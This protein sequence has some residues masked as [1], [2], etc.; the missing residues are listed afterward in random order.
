[1]AETCEAAPHVANIVLS[2]NSISN[3]EASLAGP[4]GSSMIMIKQDIQQHKGSLAD[5]QDIILTWIKESIPY[6]G[7]FTGTTP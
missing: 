1:M 2:S 5:S 6:Q 3:R 7:G 4:G